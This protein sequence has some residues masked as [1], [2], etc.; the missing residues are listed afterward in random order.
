[1]DAE[2]WS[3]IM[4]KLKKKKQRETNIF[5][6]LQEFFVPVQIQK[7]MHHGLLKNT[8]HG[9]LHLRTAPLVDNRIDFSIFQI[10]LSQYYHFVHRYGFPIGLISKNLPSLMLVQVN[11]EKLFHYYRSLC[12]CNCRRHLCM[13]SNAIVY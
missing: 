10:N 2:H 1:M 3:V 6:W 13:D 7:E 4:S 5:N 12:L 9:K 11:Y 8:F